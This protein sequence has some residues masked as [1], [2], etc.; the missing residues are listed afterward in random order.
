VPNAFADELSRQVEAAVTQLSLARSA[1]DEWLAETLVERLAELRD[2]AARSD[3]PLRL[4][5]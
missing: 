3:I 5:V 2:I 1:G 4:S